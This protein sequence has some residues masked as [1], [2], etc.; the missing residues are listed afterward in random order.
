MIPAF[1]LHLW[2]GFALEKDPKISPSLSNPASIPTG[3]GNKEREDGR[4]R[5]QPERVVSIDRSI[6]ITLS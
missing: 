6:A 1:E 4:R 2:S 3:L 5:N